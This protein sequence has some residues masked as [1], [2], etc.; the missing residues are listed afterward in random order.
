MLLLPTAENAMKHE[1]AGLQD[2]YKKFK[3]DTKDLTGAAALEAVLGEKL[4]T[5]EPKWR[6]SVMTL[7]YPR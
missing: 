1:L 4:E 3:A 5:F 6:R 2:F 7:V